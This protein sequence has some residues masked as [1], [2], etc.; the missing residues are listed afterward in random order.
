MLLHWFKTFFYDELR[1]LIHPQKIIL[2]R[3][4]RTYKHGFK[5]RVVHQQQIMLPVRARTDGDLMQLIVETLK[6]ILQK[7]EWRN[8]LPVLIVSNH[9]VHYSAIPWNK[10]IT[11]ENELQSYLTHCFIVSFGEIAKSWDIRMSALFFGRSAIASAIN[12]E[13]LSALH[14]VF[15]Q[16]NM[17]IV[18]IYPALMLAIN[19]I[20]HAI[21]TT[22]QQKILQATHW[23]V[24]IQH[25]RLCFALVE[26]GHWRLVNNVALETN[27]TEQITALIQRETVIFDVDDTAPVLLYWPE[28]QT[29][30]PLGFMK[31]KVI[32]MSPHPL[33]A[34]PLQSANT[35][36]DWALV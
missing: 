35:L 21:K 3:L 24:V 6:D 16:E 33:K 19:Q 30:Q 7:L 34:T 17:K 29:F 12:K 20:L 25:G 1:V 11:A 27:S 18:A 2:L 5:Q 26:Q 15:N 22:Q 8:S 32:K 9:F 23:L 10:E 28:S 14:R 13:F 4:K 36:P 31:N